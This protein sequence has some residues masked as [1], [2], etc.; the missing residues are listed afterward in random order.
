MAC[1]YLFS[2]GEVWLF[3]QKPARSQVWLFSCM[4]AFRALSFQDLWLATAGFIIRGQISEPECLELMPGGAFTHC[5]IAKD[6]MY[7]ETVA[8]DDPTLVTKQTTLNDLLQHGCFLLADQAMTVN[9]THLH[10]I[11]SLAYQW[12]LPTWFKTKQNC[13]TS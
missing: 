2:V 10:M 5:N 7:S 3:H 11:P 4:A 9:T 6:L 1:I 13:K 12:S 8:A